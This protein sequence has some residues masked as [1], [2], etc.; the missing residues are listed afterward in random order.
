MDPNAMP[1]GMIEWLGCLAVAVWL[2]TLV[3]D[4]VNKVRGKSPHPP[5]ESLGKDVERLEEAL[6]DE[7]RDRQRA[8][9]EE[10]EAREETD[11]VL[12]QRITSHVERFHTG[13]GDH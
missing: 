10:R 12:H 9:K 3:I 5:N 7:V 1:K 4:L 6:E 11:N 13:H 8:V 2:A